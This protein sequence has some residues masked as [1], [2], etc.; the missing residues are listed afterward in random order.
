MASNRRP[1]ALGHEP[2]PRESASKA[3][4]SG[5]QDASVDEDERTTVDDGPHRGLR[6]RW[7]E[8]T[9]QDGAGVRKRGQIF[10]QSDNLDG[11]SVAGTIERGLDAETIEETTTNDSPRKPIA[12][13]SSEVGLS[14]VDE[15]TVDDHARPL[16][17]LAIISAPETSDDEPDGDDDDEDQR[18]TRVAINAKLVVIGGNDRGREFPIHATKTTLGRGVDNDIILTDI[19]VSRR[20]MNVEFD[21]KGFLFRDLKSGNGTLLNNKRSGFSRLASGDQLE[22]GNTL[23]RF[24][25]PQA[26]PGAALSP[27]ELARAG[28]AVSTI[29]G[30]PMAKARAGLPLPVS[31]RPARGTEPPKPGGPIGGPV[32][33][34]AVPSGA[35]R[36]MPTMPVVRS[37]GLLIAPSA[38]ERRKKIFIGLAVVASVFLIAIAAAALSGD[39]EVP[40]RP[41]AGLFG[42]G[43]GDDGASDGDDDGGDGDVAATVDLPAIVVPAPE[44]EPAPEPAPEPEPEPEPVVAKTDP[45]PKPEPIIVKKDPPLPKKVVKKDPPPPKKVVKKDPPPPKKVVKKPPKRVA[46][47]TKA[48]SSRSIAASTRKAAALYK[49]QKFAAASAALRDAANDADGSEAKQLSDMAAD[50]TAVGANIDLGE[51]TRSADPPKALSAYRKALQ[52]DRRAGK[53]VHGSFIRIKL[54]EVAPRAAASFMAKKRYESAKRA[55]DAAVN[56]GAGSDPMVTR[57]RKALDKKAG[58]FYAYGVKL[59]KSNPSK[60]TAQFKRVMQMVPTDNPW[61]VK[62]YAAVNKSKKRPRDDDE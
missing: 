47:A 14:T 11:D 17:P 41:T 3:K 19:A 12:A 62:A 60:A 33:A 37:D 55:C 48:G 59:S 57:V 50:Y 35:H 22:I 32:I 1:T 15:P 13:G 8:K 2:A 24:E 49:S 52:I 58:Q 34:S 44:P 36:P 61:Y 9:V 23:I 6:D 54:G 16:P 38:A 20:H 40:E 30:R 25:C 10:P 18:P 5:N 43:G 4:T 46:T 53:G 39:G 27:A 7:E 21:G 29:A 26:A 56:Y 45:P 28:E 51:R 31:R 42:I